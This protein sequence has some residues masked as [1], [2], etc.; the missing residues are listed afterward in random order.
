MAT[1][2]GR[3]EP[4]KGRLGSR[5]VR[6]L[7]GFIALVVLVFAFL[8]FEG[9]RP[10]IELAKPIENVGELGAAAIIVRDRGTGLAH[11]D[12]ALEAS[13]TRYELASEDYPTTGWRGSGVNERLVE[14]Q[15]K[16]REAKIPEGEAK[17]V[18]RATDHSWLNLF[19]T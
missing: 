15:F 14:V 13:G 16:P 12:V 5:V 8:K 9:S 18:A 4:K 6:I 2:L 1:E 19:M 10:T 7:L 3:Q 17:L 11:V